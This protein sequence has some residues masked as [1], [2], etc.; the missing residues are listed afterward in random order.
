MILFKTVVVQERSFDQWLDGE[1]RFSQCLKR[2]LE[3]I[4]MRTKSEKDFAAWMGLKKLYKRLCRHKRRGYW[5]KK[6][7]G[8]KNKTANIWS[9]ICS[10]SGQRKK[11]SVDGFQPV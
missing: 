8:P 5:N 7:S 3:R 2:S 9:H 11:S 1:C 4:Y 10:V 6:L